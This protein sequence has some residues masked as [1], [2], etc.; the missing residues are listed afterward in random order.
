MTAI[1]CRVVFLDIC[2]AFDS[3]NH[4]IL[5][6]KL[7][8]QFGIHST[9]L[10]WFES[11]LTNRK[12][13]C[14]VNGQT[15]SSKE[16]VCEIPQGSILGPLLFLLCIN[17]M[18]DCLEKTTEYL[19]S[20]DTEISSSSDNFDTLIKNL[21]YDLNNIR[22]WLSK[23][24]LKHHPTKSKVMFIGSSS[25]LN[26]KVKDNCVLLN[27]APISRADTFTC[28][29]VDLDEKLSCRNTL[30]NICGKVSAGIVAMRRI[31][32]FVPPVTL[33]TIYKTLVQPYFDYCLPLWIIAE[34]YSKIN[35]KNFKIVQLGLSPEPATMLDLLMCSTP[36][37]GRHLMQDDREIN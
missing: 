35:Y 3:I 14:S 26:K 37:A 23:N 34:K 13:V 29:G 17:D 4:E 31:K 7:K 9:E 25:N 20:D 21:N 28:L 32:L 18:T 27:N 1:R 33:Q 6:R 5:L 36:L 22:K 8:D 10:K 30:K 19:Y 2:K 16:I 11:Y 15:S 12:Q 24:K